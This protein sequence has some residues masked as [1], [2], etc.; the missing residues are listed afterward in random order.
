M[1]TCRDR[2]WVDAHFRGDIHPKDEQRMRQ[3]L[4]G[5]TQCMARYNKRLIYERIDPR[6][7]GVTARLERGL[8]LRRRRAVDFFRFAVPAACILVALVFFVIPRSSEDVGFRSR[9][10]KG[11]ESRRAVE[12]EVGIEVYRV[13]GGRSVRAQGAID[14]ADDLAFA[15]RNR[16]GKRRL[17]LFGM[18]EQSNIEWYQP[19]WSDASANPT[20]VSIEKGADLREL[21]EA[22]ART[23]AGPSMRVTAW[24]VD[25]AITVR[26]AEILIRAGRTPP[27]AAVTTEVLQ[28]HQEKRR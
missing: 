20:A 14:A 13:R 5:C 9:G 11:I 4:P 12:P 1:S 15:Y 22:I 16:A 3:H 18:D 28:V 27:G 21:P 6:A 10:G 26:Q 19:A 25:D 7:I 17:L 2:A 8:G 23:L 24:F